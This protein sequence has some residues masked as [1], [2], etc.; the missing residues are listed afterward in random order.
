MNPLFVVRVSDVSKR[1]LKNLILI[2]Q[3]LFI[4]F[5]DIS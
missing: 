5:L 2:I 4:F 1:L 3:F